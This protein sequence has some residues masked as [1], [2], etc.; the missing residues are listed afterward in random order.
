MNQPLIWLHEEALRVTHPVFRAAPEGTRAIYVWDDEY[1]RQ[2]DYSLKRLVFMY[3]TLCELPV[4]ILRGDTVSIIKQIAPSILYIPA[5]TKPHI[6]ATISKIKS[7]ANVEMIP[8]ENFVTIAKAAD[9]R[10]FFPY[11]NIAQ[12]T[13]FQKNGGLDA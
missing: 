1:L 12:K 13:A 7:V 5:T 4:E 6:E 11:W 2:L 3:E 10:R 8:D 9:V